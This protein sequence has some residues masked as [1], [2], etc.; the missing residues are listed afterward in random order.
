MGIVTGYLSQLVSSGIKLLNNGTA[1]SSSNPL[2]VAASIPTESTTSSVA[3]Q[4]DTVYSANDSIGAGFTFTG[5]LTTGVDSGVITG[6]TL[7]FDS[8]SLTSVIDAYVF[9]AAPTTV[10]TDG[11]AF[12]LTA[13]DFA[14]LVTVIQVPV[15]SSLGASGISTLYEATDLFRPISGT[16]NGT[17][18]VVLVAESATTLTTLDLQ[19]IKL[20]GLKT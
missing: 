7:G 14:N 5:F 4:V 8:A 9:R 18:Y 13:T 2:P 12:V 19:Q 11:A 20:V 15:K 1:V 16:T 6:I 3:S 10:P 17:V